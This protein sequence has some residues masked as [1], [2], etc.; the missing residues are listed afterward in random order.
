MF[1]LQKLG[2]KAKIKLKR[3]RITTCIYYAITHFTRRKR[4]PHNYAI[5]HNVLL[6][7][8]NCKHDM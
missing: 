8:K 3:S 2:T 5:V 4:S 1:V 6:I 7:D